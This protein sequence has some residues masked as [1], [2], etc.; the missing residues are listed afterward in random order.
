MIEI[1]GS[2]LGRRAFG[3][4]FG[5]GGIFGGLGVPLERIGSRS[6]EDTKIFGSRGNVEFRPGRDVMGEPQP[7][8]IGEGS[9]ELLLHW[10]K[11]SFEDVEF[12]TSNELSGVEDRLDG[13]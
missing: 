9:E 2:L 11:V 13:Y 12:E 5:P 3:D 7:N 10:N 6:N 1:D 4:E 8:L